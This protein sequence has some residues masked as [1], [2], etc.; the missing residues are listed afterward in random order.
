MKRR[1]RWWLSA[2]L[3]YLVSVPVVFISI[4]LFVYLVVLIWITVNGL[5]G[6]S[7]AGYS[8]LIIYFMFFFG[9]PL[10]LLSSLFV[11]SIVLGW[12]RKRRLRRLIRSRRIGL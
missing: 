7:Q 12:L 10:S 1:V 6:A 9:I 3:L 4:G 5:V 8:L 2:V 11:P